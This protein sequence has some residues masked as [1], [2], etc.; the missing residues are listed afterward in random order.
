M[1]KTPQEEREIKEIVKLA[2]NDNVYAQHQIMCNLTG[3]SVNLQ[4]LM[5]KQCDHMLETPFGHKIA[6]GLLVEGGYGNGWAIAEVICSNC[7]KTLGFKVRKPKK[8]K[9]RF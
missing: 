2:H 5:P 8:P 4:A 6:L 7:A 3:K 9:R 1:N